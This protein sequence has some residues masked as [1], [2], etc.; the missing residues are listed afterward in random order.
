MCIRDS[1][2][3]IVANSIGGDIGTGAS[4]EGVVGAGSFNLIGDG[5]GEEGLDG[6]NLFNLTDTVTGDPLLGPLADNGG[7]TLTHALLPGSPA[8]DAGN[9]AVA[10]TVD[11]RGLARNVNG[12]DIGAFEAQPAGA[13]SVTSFARDEGGA[14]ETLARP[15]LL[16]QVAVEFSADVS[17]SADDLVVRNLSLI[18]ISEPTRPY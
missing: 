1:I 4:A 13:L 10:E 16:N 11:Q 14:I 9:D 5:G 3:S 8:I 17:I 2:N 18:H 12:V 15:D 6:F 7:P